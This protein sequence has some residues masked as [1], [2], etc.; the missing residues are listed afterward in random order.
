MERNEEQQIKVILQNS[1]TEAA[2]TVTLVRDWEMPATELKAD[3]DDA[4]YHD[5]VRLLLH[6][7]ICTVGA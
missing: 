2:H 4:V 7:Q 1:D 5:G 3:S 6:G